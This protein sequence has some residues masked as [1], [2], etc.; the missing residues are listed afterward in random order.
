MKAYS[1]TAPPR[2]YQRCSA[3][4]G[5]LKQ[6]GVLLALK[7]VARLLILVPTYAT[8]MTI[9]VPTWRS[10]CTLY[11]CTR[12]FLLLVGQ[13]GKG[14]YFLGGVFCFLCVWW[15]GGGGGGG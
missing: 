9:L 12:E 5:P 13:R 11:C 2:L 15:G 6:S 10:N 8:S 7:A 3:H 1:L 14:L 4:G